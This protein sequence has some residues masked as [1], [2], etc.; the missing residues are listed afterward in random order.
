[1]SPI[2]LRPQFCGLINIQSKVFLDS[3][4]DMQLRIWDKAPLDPTDGLK[5]AMREALKGCGLS[6]PQVAEK[7]AE[8]A[9]EEGITVGGRSQKVT[10]PLLD[11]WVARGARS[12]VIP[13]RLL[14]IF[15]RVAGSILPLKALSNPVGAEVVVEEDAR[16]LE[17]ARA[18]IRHRECRKAARRLAQQAGVEP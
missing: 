15:C 1:M 14:P 11:K 13:V 12:Y 8:L 7:M 4:K 17:W 10:L 2:N 3:T 16:L 18:E 9:E 6:R 5:T